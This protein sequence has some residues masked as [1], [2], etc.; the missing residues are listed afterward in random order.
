MQVNEFVIDKPYVEVTSWCE[1]YCIFSYNY[2]SSISVKKR[3]HQKMFA[4]LTLMLFCR[5]LNKLCY[6]GWETSGLKPSQLS[7]Y[8]S[9]CK[10]RIQTVLK[11]HGLS[12]IGFNFLNSKLNQWAVTD[13]PSHPS[14]FPAVP[15]SV[16]GGRACSFNESRGNY[17]VLDSLQIFPLPVSLSGVSAV[18]DYTSQLRCQ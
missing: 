16:S 6:D 13:L 7:A 11:L 4:R 18:W 10:R 2:I 1:N 3:G 17:T 9:V 14:A 12:K 5:T 8:L 15:S